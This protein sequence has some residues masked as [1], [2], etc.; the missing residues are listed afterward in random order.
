[1]KP[2]NVT[3]LAF[4]SG[5]V[6][7]C[8]GFTS[9]SIAE[10][11]TGSCAGRVV[12]VDNNPVSDL[13]VF[14]G[15][16]EIDEDGIRTGL[17]P[18]DY[19]SLRRAR[20]DAE[21]R[22]S[23]TGIPSGV[24]YFGAL[25]HNVEA[26]LPRQLAEMDEAEI[27]ALFLAALD[28]DTI[29]ALLASSFG[30]E[31]ADFEPDVEILGLHIQGLSFY[32]RADS[33]KIGFEVEPGAHIK[34][35]EVTVKPRMR[36]R[37]QIL[38]KDGTPLANARVNLEVYYR[39]DTPLGMSG[40]R[41][42]D[43]PWTDAEGYFVHYL[44]ERDDALFYTL[45]V[46][47]KELEAEA[48]PVL[49]KPGERY[50]GLVLTFD[51]EPISTEQATPLITVPSAETVEPKPTSEEVWIGNPANGHAY[52][53]IYCE[54]R[55]E[56][57]AQAAAENAHLLTLNDEEEQR[58]IAAVFGSECYWIGLSRAQGP[59]EW[60]WDNGEPLTYENWLPDDFFD[61]SVAANERRAAVMT[62]SDGKW[63]AVG[64][65]SI[66]SRI[67]RMAIIEKEITP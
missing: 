58:W 21:G 50:D 47:Y 3:F 63:Y 41:G 51:S 53:R 6:A 12:D 5:I 54:T 64:A 14:I 16:A 7:I 49:L 39:T 60:Q 36:I 55:D 45:T 32:P 22:F 17:F 57:L 2:L 19:P 66:I 23:L 42:G 29:D 10:E 35:M 31:H 48:E 59:A 43:S 61:E 37:G 34:G 65:G 20:T 18:E 38:F 67:T 52:K 24:M 15:P 27:E 11:G 8:L 25:P 56:A 13:E 30:M 26:R 33:D 28:A 40:G 4:L 46:A 1:M 62:F 9:D 44:D